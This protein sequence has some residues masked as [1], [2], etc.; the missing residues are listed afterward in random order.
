[1]TE[2]DIRTFGVPK[3]E[4]RYPEQIIYSLAVLYNVVSTDIA[5]FLRQYNLS[6][7]KFNILLAIR[8]YSEPNGIRQVDISQHLIVTASNMT[9]MLDKL[10]A[11]GLVE[12]QV[13]KSDRRVKMIQITAIGN[14]LIDTLWSK[15]QTLLQQSVSGL[16]TDKQ[17]Q[18]A[19]LL[20]EWFECK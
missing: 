10:Q 13:L 9:K 5:Q 2:I 11:D 17:T 8:R 14:G 20:T 18:L 6:L 3:G 16:Q 15:Y 7:G 19:A 4:G 1:M 12:R